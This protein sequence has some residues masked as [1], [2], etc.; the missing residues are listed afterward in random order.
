MLCQRFGN[1][2]ATSLFLIQY[3]FNNRLVVSIELHGSGNDDL[4]GFVSDIQDGITIEQLDNDGNA[5]GESLILL[6]D[7]QVLLVIQTKKGLLRF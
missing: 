7:I 1:L 5:D 4:Q 2:W 6:N 3:A